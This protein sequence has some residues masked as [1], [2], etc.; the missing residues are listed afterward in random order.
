[1]RVGSPVAQADHSKSD[2]AVQ[3]FLPCAINH[4]LAATTDYFQQLIVAKV[5]E[6]VC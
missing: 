1:M 6:R 3:T 2:G 4:T 5:G